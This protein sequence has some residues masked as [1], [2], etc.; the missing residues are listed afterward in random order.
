MLGKIVSLL[1]SK[2]GV[3]RETAA[4][5][6]RRIT[7]AACV[8][9]LEM[10]RA[11]EDLAASELDQVR[12]VLSGGLGVAPDDVDSIL[13]IAGREQEEATDLWAYTNLINEHFDKA[14]KQRLIEMA[15]EIAYA[16]GRLDQNEDYLVHKIANL[17]HVP[18]SD[19]IAAKLKAKNG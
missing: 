4:D 16:D 17:L 18:H 7:I 2:N 11:D 1:A 8:I 9:L 12:K 13:A 15:W 10:A 3:L 6:N 14:E 19:L 5:R